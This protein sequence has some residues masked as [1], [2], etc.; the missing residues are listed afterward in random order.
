MWCQM[1][2]NTRGG[3]RRGSKKH[4]GELYRD[5]AR[6]VPMEQARAWPLKSRN[7]AT[8]RSLRSEYRETIDSVRCY[9][10]EDRSGSGVMVGWWDSI[11]GPSPQ[12]TARQPS[13][14]AAMPGLQPY[15]QMPDPKASVTDVRGIPDNYAAG[16]NKTIWV[17]LTLPSY[18]PPITAD[19]RRPA[20]RSDAGCWP[21][22]KS[23][24]F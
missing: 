4:L 1:L 14:R 12:R 9:Y 2:N 22:V 16:M 8:W 13:S 24:G 3:L 20:S 5:C 7:I 18:A 10:V 6:E 11:F 15:Q 19:T 23:G 21:D 17:E